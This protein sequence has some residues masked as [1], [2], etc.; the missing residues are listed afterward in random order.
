M[1]AAVAE[2]RADAEITGSAVGLRTS[3]RNSLRTLNEIGATVDQLYHSLAEKKRA[4]VLRCKNCRRSSCADFQALA[5]E[6]NSAGRAMM[7][8]RI[9][10]NNTAQPS[11]VCSDG[12]DAAQC[13][14]DLVKK[15]GGMQYLSSNSGA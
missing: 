3:Q 2:K 7:R 4:P 13:R 15:L 12:S 10:H 11:W 5:R 8:L 14:R 1:T 6:A 9:D